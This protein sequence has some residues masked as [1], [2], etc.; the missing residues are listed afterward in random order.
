VQALAVSDDGSK[1]VGTS[2]G[3]TG[4]MRP[5]IWTAATGMQELSNIPGT[6][7]VASDIS[8]DG[9]TVVGYF[10]DSAGDHA[11][12]WNAGAVKVLPGAPNGFDAKGE[13]VCGAGV[14]VVGSAVMSDQTERAAKW[15]SSGAITLLAQ[16]AGALSY[17]EGCSN[18]GSVVIGTGMDSKGNLQPTRWDSAGSR[19][20]GTLGGNSG[21]AHGVSGDGT[22]VVGAAGLP[23]INGVSEFSAFRW[24][25]TAGKMEQ[26]SKT[27]QGLGVG[28]PFCHQTPCAAGT[29][30]LQ[31]ALGVSGDGS[32]IVGTAVDPN[33]NL[34]AFRA[35]VPTGSTATTPPP[36]TGACP[37]GYTQVTLSVSASAGTGSVT[38]S[39]TSAS[40][41]KLKVA[42]GQTGSACF[43]SNRTLGLQATRLSDWGGTPNI[44]CKSGNLGQS[45]CEFQLGTT[46]QGVTS[47]LK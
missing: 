4:F 13:A 23:F 27:L 5:F 39:Q 20:L 17:T 31:L 16:S 34:Q 37:S 24:T 30:F 46:K 43:Q 15:S 14:G 11:F 2:R 25:S 22:V 18:T 19:S 33:G 3:V 36:T 9:N 42:S 21:E 35:V 47:V 45:L 8:P 1:V 26:L 41:T 10:F 38:S 28:T 32:T 12:M 40:G 7:A 44:I 6:D 29:W